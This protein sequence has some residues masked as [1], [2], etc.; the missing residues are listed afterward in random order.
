LLRSLLIS[1]LPQHAP[2]PISLFQTCGCLDYI[3]GLI[4]SWRSALQLLLAL[5]QTATKW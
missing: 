2:L 5:A 4:N 3:F 1:P